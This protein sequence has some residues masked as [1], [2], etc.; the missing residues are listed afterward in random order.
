[1]KGAKQGGRRAIVVAAAIAA[2][3]TAIGVAVP[4]L[5]VAAGPG[6]AGTGP[7]GNGASRVLGAGQTGTRAQVPWGLVGPGWSLAQF[8]ASTAGEGIKPVSGPSTLYLVDPAGG[9]YKMITWRARSLQTTWYLQAWSGD[10]SRAMFVPQ[11]SLNNP[12]VRQQVFQLKLQT[13]TITQFTLPLRVA[14]VGYT[15]PDGLNILTQE[16]SAGRAST[17]TLQ[18]YSLTGKLVTT[19]ATAAANGT[20]AYQPDGAELAASSPHGLVLIS[21]AGGVIRQLRVDRGR[22]SCTAVRWWTASKI[23]AS[24]V[25]TGQYGYNMWIVPASGAA[26]AVLT[27]AHKTVTFDVGDFNAW[28]LSSGLYVDGYGACATLVIGKYPAHGPEQQVPVPGAASS[29]I[30]TATR[31]QLQVERSNGCEPGVALVW[32]DPPSR[33]LTVA[34]GVHGHQIGVVS[35]VPFFV[36]GRF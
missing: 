15:R 17:V 23:L 1:M 31:G 18:R 21:N 34:V 24:C 10:L 27:P 22:E 5:A 6:P 8:S 11:V 35:V 16:G 20:P 32:F 2:A 30:V 4:A 7:A 28:K 29:V 3:A 12:Y 33:K 36:T 19:L 14:A 9:R 25:R 26:A 13:G